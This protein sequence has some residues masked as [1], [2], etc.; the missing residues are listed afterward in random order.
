MCRLSDY[1]GFDSS[2]T[3]RYDGD[4]PSR[5]ELARDMPPDDPIGGTEQDFPRANLKPLI[6][7]FSKKRLNSQSPAGS[8]VNHE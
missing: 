8:G 2:L 7:M 1:D 5:E 3:G 4:H 6:P